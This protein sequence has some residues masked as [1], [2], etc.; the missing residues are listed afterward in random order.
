M[1]LSKSGAIPKARTQQ[2]LSRDLQ[3]IQLGAAV[4]D[5]VCLGYKFNA[6]ASKTSKCST[7]RG[8]KST[9]GVCFGA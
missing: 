3:D 4:L 8:N 6:P 2:Q 9:A 1:W 5:K 7:G